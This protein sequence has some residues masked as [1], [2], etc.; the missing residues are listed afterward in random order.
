M[1]AAVLSAL[2]VFAQPIKDYLSYKQK[3]TE[4]NRELELAKI[5]ADKEAIISG[6]QAQS[7]QIQSYLNATSR[8]FRQGTFYF[9]MVP[10]LISM[11]APEYA[12]VMWENFAAIPHEFK[13]LFFSIY[14]VIWGLPIAKENVGLM[15]SSIGRAVEARREYKLKINRDAVFAQVRSKWFPRGM[16]Q[17]QVADLDGALDAGE[18]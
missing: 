1:L 7:N 11:A 13:L 9:F 17:T 4:S 6:N 15:F 2:S 10:F 8:K 12:K 18:K 16:S 5:Q 14:G 3:L